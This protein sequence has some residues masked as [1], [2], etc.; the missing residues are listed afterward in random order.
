MNPS[1]AKEIGFVERFALAENRAD[2]L[3]E[4]IPGTEDY[5]YFHALHYQNT[6]EKTK[7][8]G[9]LGQWRKRF[10]K[11]SRRGVLENRQALIGYED[12]PQATLDYLKKALGLHFNHQ[13]ERKQTDPSLATT[14][15]PALISMDAIVKQALRDDR[16][17][18]EVGSAGI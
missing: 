9:I 18:G 11:S 1:H 7:F 2:V 5:Y 16:K 17:L 3:E 8:N 4:L 15:D 13:R 10:E 14:L 6:G 12:N